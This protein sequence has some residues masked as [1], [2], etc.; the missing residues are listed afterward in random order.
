MKPYFYKIKEKLTGKYYVGCQYGK[1]SDPAQ[2]WVTYFTSNNYV[3]NQPLNSFTI[4]YIKER[5]D[6]REYEK[7]YLR[8]CYRLLGRNKFLDIFINR[9]LAPGIL[10]TPEIILKANEKRKISNSIA[11]KKRI[12]DGTHNFLSNKYVPTLEHKEKLSLRMRGNQL[13]KKVNRNEEYRKK[14]AE[15]SKGNT[16][17]RGKKWWNDGV[18]RKRAFTQPGCEWVEGYQLKSIYEGT[19][20]HR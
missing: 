7:R 20:A 17:V 1:K 9:N 16:N 10:N 5:K 14:Q 2:F 12:E 15:L 8:K 11:A 13:G 18:R 6:A 3:K 19:K 4:I